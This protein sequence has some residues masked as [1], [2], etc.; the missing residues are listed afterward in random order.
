M[1]NSFC[2]RLLASRVWKLGRFGLGEGGAL[3]SQSLDCFTAFAMTALFMGCFSLTASQ[4]RTAWVFTKRGDKCGNL[5]QESKAKFCQ[6]CGAVKFQRGF[7]SV[8]LV[9][10]GLKASQWRAR[11]AFAMTGRTKW[12]GEG[13]LKSRVVK[14]LKRQ[15]FKSKFARGANLRWLKAKFKV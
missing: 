5:S 8:G 2:V 9:C 11:G 6:K 13:A 12:D 14:K 10:F 4:W 7:K 3:G 1:K 15:H